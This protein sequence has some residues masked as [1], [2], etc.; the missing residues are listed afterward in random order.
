MD[1]HGSGVFPYTSEV[2]DRWLREFGRYPLQRSPGQEAMTVPDWSPAVNISETADEYVLEV[3]L[4]GVR[5]E[6]VTTRQAAWRP[7]TRSSHA[8]AERSVPCCTSRTSAVR[9]SSFCGVSS[10]WRKGCSGSWQPVTCFGVG[11]GT[12]MARRNR[13]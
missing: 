6:G 7:S 4:Y 11:L 10:D 1:P 5:R 8:Q 2:L 3:E 9:G 13:R 12:S